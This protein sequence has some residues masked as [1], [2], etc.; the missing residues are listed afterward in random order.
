[1]VVN[2][3]SAIVPA[4]NEEKSIGNVLRELSKSELIDEIIVIDDGSTDNTY[5]KAKKFPKVKILKNRINKGKGF[6]MCKGVNVSK[7]NI[8]FFCDADLIGLNVNIINNIIKP[9]KENKVAMFI[10]LRNNWSYRIISF[11]NLKLSC[12]FISG[13]R[14]LKKEIWEKTP[15]F[16]KKDFRIE[17]GLNY[18]SKFLG[19]GFSYKV[20]NYKQ[21]IK[22]K[23]HGLIKGLKSRFNMNKYLVIANLYSIEKGVLKNG[24]T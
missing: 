17:T 12:L 19:K 4:Y 14:A 18:Y 22:E 23:K 1:M 16:Y 2:K 5:S 9:V 8:I 7:H 3:V 20:F 10:G 24:H 6:S 13:E 15:N 11:F 21:T